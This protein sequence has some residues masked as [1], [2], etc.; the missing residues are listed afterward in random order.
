MN[1]A[2]WWQSVNR[3]PFYERVGEAAARDIWAAAVRASM[4]RLHER[5]GDI[6]RTSFERAVILCSATWIED[7]LREGVSR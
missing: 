2:E 4:E 3:S 6:H 5:A 1:F 7:G